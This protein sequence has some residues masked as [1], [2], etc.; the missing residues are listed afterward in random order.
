ML[1]WLGFS[2]DLHSWSP[3]W[4]VCANVGRDR[5]SHGLSSV[6]TCNC[7]QDLHGLHAI[8]SDADILG[9]NVSVYGI[10]SCTDK[11][12]ADRAQILRMGSRTSGWRDAR[13]EDKLG[14][15]GEKTQWERVQMRAHLVNTTEVLVFKDPAE[16]WRMSRNPGKRKLLWDKP[17]LIHH[18]QSFPMLAT[19]G[20]EAGRKGLDYSEL[21]DESS[22]GLRRNL[23]AVKDGCQACCVIFLSGCDLGSEQR[24]HR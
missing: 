16:G 20:P 12:D 6:I 22:S 7:H 4:E 21:K 1:P 5:K 14:G 2:C 23:Q 9:A 11:K 8:V 13:G 10:I 15:G 17:V 18:I 3:S 19:Q 24:K